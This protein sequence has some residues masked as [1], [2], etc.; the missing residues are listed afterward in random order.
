MGRGKHL[1]TKAKE[2]RGLMQAM[3]VGL[4]S[5]EIAAAKKTYKLKNLPYI[6]LKK[7]DELKSDQIFKFIAI[8]GTTLIVKGGIEW[9][10]SVLTT[11]TGFLSWLGFHGLDPDE[12][13]EALD[14][15]QVE[16]V[17]WLLSFTAAYLIVENFGEL[18]EAGT[19]IITAAQGMVGSAALAA[20]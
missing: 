18:V 10:E 6:I 11:F 5:G 7:F 19:N 13:A 20:G 12:L 14:M 9:S 15:P 1:S 3:M 8:L 17:Q 2:M 4:S 16:M